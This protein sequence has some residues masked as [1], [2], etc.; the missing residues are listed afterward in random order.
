M[1]RNFIGAITNKSIWTI[2]LLII[3]IWSSFAFYK[4]GFDK[5]EIEHERIIL[6][7]KMEIQELRDLITELA[8]VNQFQ[9]P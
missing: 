1:M 6:N 9:L 7:Q 2:L 4:E 5:A 8:K 3:A